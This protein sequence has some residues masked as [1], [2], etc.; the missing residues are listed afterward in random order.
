MKNIIKGFILGISV[1]LLMGF[2]SSSG[3]CGKF[4]VITNC[5][6]GKMIMMDTSTAHLYEYDTSFNHWKKIT[7][8][9]HIWD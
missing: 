2:S 4:Q 3:G 1:I 6:T 8:G 5:D 7:F 9:N